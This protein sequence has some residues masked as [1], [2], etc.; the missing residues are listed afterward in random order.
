MT[1]RLVKNGGIYLYGP[2]GFYDLWNDEGFTS[3][4]V[5]TA[6][7][8]IEGDVTVHINSGG[9]L[10]FDGIAIHNAL[11]QHDGEVTV[12]VDAIA[13]SAAS[14]IAMAGDLVVM[15]PGAMLMIHNAAGLTVGTA[16]AHRETADMLD[17]LDG[18][19]ASIYARATGIGQGEIRDMMRATTWFDADEAVERNFADHVEGEADAAEPVA[20]AAWDYREYAGA[21]EQLVACAERL[22]ERGRLPNVRNQLTS[23]RAAAAAF[24]PSNGGQSMTTKQTNT[25]GGTSPVALADAS[26]DQVREAHP[27]LIA[28]VAADAANAERARILGIENVALPGY[29]DEIA[30]F[31]AD[32]KTTPEQ[33]AMAIVAAERKTGGR[34]LDDLAADDADAAAVTAGAPRSGDGF[35][36]AS[37]P[38]EWRA[39]WKAS[40]DLQNEY[41]TA[42]AYAAFMGNRG[43]V[44]GIRDAA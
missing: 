8:E 4:D 32:G 3:T 1:H 17:K 30:A 23:I 38:D 25:A 37:T 31:K 34:R 42:D 40:A 6:L 9:G 24:Q 7:S 26:A 27:D 19:L 14:I 44:R 12:I 21:P 36:K 41:P 16:I 28:Q 20:F 39:E 11:K 18:S 35:T 2:V 13:A 22:D 33:A 43:K 5:L 29:D 10:A 15:Q